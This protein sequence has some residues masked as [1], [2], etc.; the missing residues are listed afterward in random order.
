MGLQNY[1][2]FASQEKYRRSKFFPRRIKFG[3]I[4]EHRQKPEV[5]RKVSEE[6]G[7]KEAS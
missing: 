4:R 5:S 1:E 2:R 6:I 3:H 7:R